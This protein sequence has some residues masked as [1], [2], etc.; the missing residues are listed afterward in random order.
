MLRYS[1]GVT[2]TTTTP[3]KPDEGEPGRRPRVRRG[4]GSRQRGGAE[5]RIYLS[6]RLTDAAWRG[7][8]RGACAGEEKRAGRARGGGEGRSSLDGVVGR[9]SGEGLGGPGFE[10]RAPQWKL[11]GRPSATLRLPA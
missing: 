4:G 5:D 9:V 7:E 10:S 2:L 1:S 3:K 8:A 11:S 6:G